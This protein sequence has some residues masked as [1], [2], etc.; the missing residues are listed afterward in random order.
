MKIEI[1]PKITWVGKIDYELRKFHGDQIT[2]QHGSSYNS[3]L[4][5]DEKN[6]LIDA[7]YY[8]YADEFLS[9]LQNEIKLDKIDIIVVNHSEPDHS[10]AIAKLM[11]IIPNTP[12]YCT[13]TGAKALKGQYHK[14]WNFVVV[15]NGDSISTGNDEL[16][17]I[18]APM[19]HWPDTM[20]CYLKNE[21]ILFSNDVF[22]QHIAEASMFD[23]LVD[24]C[25]LFYE[26]EKYFANIIS[27]FSKKAYKKLV[28][29]EKMNLEFNL[30]CPAH[31]VMWRKNIDKILQLYK[32][33]TNAELDNHITIVYDSMYGNTRKIAEAITRGIAQSN[34]DIKFSLHNISKS[35]GSDII[36]D[37]FRSK[38]VIV[39]S[40]AINNGILNSIAGILEEISNLDTTNK[41]A[42]AFG[43]Y[44]WSPKAIDGIGEKLKNSGYLVELPVLKVQ[45]SPDE[46]QLSKAEAFG[47]EFALSLA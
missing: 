11:E 36:T 44:G 42:A 45:W 34:K 29:I 18:E 17:F 16:I 8:P 9:N 30:I 6:I 28:E 38:G 40:S 2:T 22:G 10:G 13:A 47:K 33:W 19:M 31:G 39:G 32:K 43:S 24:E 35:D 26:S 14:D 41:K 4:I 15:K 27:P 21:K 20:M 5:K 37:I 23:D 46:E 3:Y 1:T 25:I 7:V 12:I